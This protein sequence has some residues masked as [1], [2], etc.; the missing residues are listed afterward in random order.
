MERIELGG[1][2][3]LWYKAFPIHVGLIRATAADPSG[4]L[5]MDDEAII[6]E[7]LADRRSRA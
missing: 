1:K 7:V 6:G 5:V 3:W 2:T 4:G